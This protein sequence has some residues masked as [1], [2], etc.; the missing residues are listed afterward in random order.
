MDYGWDVW[1][2]KLFVGHNWLDELFSLSSKQ[3]PIQGLWHEYLLHTCSRKIPSFQ[4]TCLVH[5]QYTVRRNVSWSECTMTVIPFRAP[6]HKDHLV[7]HHQRDIGVDQ[8]YLGSTLVR[9]LWQQSYCSY[10][11]LVA[12]WRMC[13]SLDSSSAILLAAMI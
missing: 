5:K 7:P 12:S 6:R 4:Y 9:N 13:Q 8:C 11:S 10:V 2:S 1:L 3:L